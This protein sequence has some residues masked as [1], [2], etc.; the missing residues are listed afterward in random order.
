MESLIHGTCI[1]LGSRAALLRGAP[2]A[3][4]SDLALRFIDMYGAIAGGEAA[5]LVSDDQTRLV[6][7]GS[8]LIASAPDAIK[9]Q[10]EVRGVGIVDVATRPDAILALVVDLVDGADIER[11]PAEPAPRESI[12]GLTIPVIRLAP[13][14]ASAPVKLKLAIKGAL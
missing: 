13:F 6:V 12:L 3:G 5:A 4:K 2:G 14:E 10:I 8:E 9:G 7:R 1:A 11:L